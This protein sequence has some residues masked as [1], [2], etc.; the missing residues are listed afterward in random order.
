L[1]LLKFPFAYLAVFSF[2]LLSCQK[3][4]N[5]NL[6]PQKGIVKSSSSSFDTIGA[7]HNSMLDDYYEIYSLTGP[8]VDL[9]S[10]IDIANSYLQSIGNPYDLDFIYNEVPQLLHTQQLVQ[11]SA[12]SL[13]EAKIEADS[14]HNNHLMSDNIYPYVTAFFDSLEI[15]GSVSQLEEMILSLESVIGSDSNLSS[16]EQDGLLM[17]MSISKASIGYQP[18]YVEIYGIPW[19]EKDLL[20]A[21]LA[22]ST[23]TVEF[24]AFFGPWAAAGVF[25]GVSAVASMVP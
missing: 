24:A 13:A 21:A 18:T 6:S 20:G 14:M 23:G 7:H 10:K 16:E 2:A 17:V 3:S 19:Y 9:S 22:L 5:H 8:Q 4:E 25:V 15:H 11:D 12:F 1:K